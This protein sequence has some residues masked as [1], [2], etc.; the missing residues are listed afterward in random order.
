MALKGKTDKPWAQ[1]LQ[2]N[3]YSAPTPERAVHFDM[4]EAAPH[5][6]L[7]KLPANFSERLHEHKVLTTPGVAEGFAHASKVIEDWKQSL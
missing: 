1:A 6:A 2:G 5:T 4:G 3:R 7:K